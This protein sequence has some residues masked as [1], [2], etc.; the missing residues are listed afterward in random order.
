MSSYARKSGGPASAAPASTSTSVAPR[1]SNPAAPE[2]KK[3]GGVLGWFQDAGDWV[4]DKYKTVSTAVGNA[5]DTTKRVAGDVWDVVKTTDVSL[6]DGKLA[7]DTDLDEVMDLMPE[8]VK[9]RVQLGQGA[10][11]RIKLQYDGKTNALSASS[12]DLEIQGMDLGA[13]SMGPSRFKDVSVTVKNPADAIQMLEGTR[14]ALGD[15]Q[16]GVSIDVQVGQANASNVSVRGANGTTTRVNQF[17]AKDFHGTASNTDGLPLG[18]QARGTRA[19]FSL[20]GASLSGVSQGDQK[21]GGLDV[22][23]LAGGLSESE[24]TAWLS[25]GSV[26]AQGVAGQQGALGTASASDVRVDIRNEGGGLVGLDDKVDHLA[27]SVTASAASVGDANVGGTQ[28]GQAGVTG[29][30]LTADQDKST[31]ALAAAGVTGQ[32]LAQ[33]K[34]RVGGLQATGLEASLGPAGWAA[35]LDSGAVTQAALAGY[36]LKGAQLSGV[37]ASSSEAGLKGSVGQASVQGLNGNGV[38]VGSGTVNSLTGSQTADG[39]SAGFAGASASDASGFGFGVDRARIGTTQLSST[40]GA[41]QGSVA[42]VDLKGLDGQGVHANS[43]TAQDLT[44]TKDANGWSAGLSGATATGASGHGFGADR[45][46]LG[47][48]T[49]SSSGG[50]LQGTVAS[51]N[52]A[53]VTGKGAQVDSLTAHGIAGSKDATGWDAAIAGATAQGADYGEYHLKQGAVS[54]VSLSG[55]GQGLT[56]QVGTLGAQGLTTDA[57]SSIAGA[58]ASGLRLTTTDGGLDATARKLGV[59]GVQLGEV[60]LGSGSATG[61]SASVRGDNTSLAAAAVNATDFSAKAFDAGG[62]AATDAKIELGKDAMSASLA[63]GSLT[64]A[65]ILDQ[66]HLDQASVTAASGS[67][68]GNRRTTDV[69]SLSATGITA[70]GTSVATANL[71]GLHGTS[72]GDRHTATLDAGNATSIKSGD[73]S[74]ARAS[75]DDL[76]LA[77]GGGVTR[78][79]AEQLA[80]TDARYGKVAQADTLTA[81]GINGQL[82]PKGPSGTVSSLGATGVDFAVAP[83]GPSTGASGFDAAS[84]IRTGA[85]RLDDAQARI[86]APMVA[87]EYKSGVGLEVDRGTRLDASVGITDN[88]LTDVNA[89]FSKPVDGPLWTELRGVYDEDGKVK[90]DVAGWFDKDLTGTINDAMGVRGDRLATVG[91]YGAAAANKLGGPTAAT[92]ATGGKPGLDQAINW[93]AMTAQGSASF[94]PGLIDAGSTEVVLGQGGRGANTVQAQAGN[95]QASVHSDKLVIDAA[96]SQV[97]GQTLTTGDAAVNGLDVRLDTAGQGKGAVSGSVSSIKVEDLKLGR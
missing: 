90:A 14:E 42:S 30:A 22:K 76:T 61:V 45:A 31:L 58:N 9:K 81:N 51:L 8:S 65:T 84:L 97:A 82:G 86:S 17:A 20:G 7:V 52:A 78:G 48:T 19:S 21:L 40:N 66:V 74:V 12:K 37:S 1:A 68:V 70:G 56:A 2:S 79:G 25:V 49:L 85:Q 38:S 4:A 91:T 57:G 24:E 6:Q 94:T 73:V 83:G 75:V 13:L 55:N 53:G 88:R 96:S 60:G 44:G 28:L 43:L 35:E 54:G 26:N 41:V 77:T 39:W 29:L 67:V 62:I 10:E 89:S 80:L 64:D 33:G 34:N 72:Q 3:R 23:D 50:E 27:A 95:G 47:A 15:T 69:G 11:N 93:G 46:T 59:E 87:G 18:D 16:D 63:T 5:V 32:N 71:T 92:P 36:D